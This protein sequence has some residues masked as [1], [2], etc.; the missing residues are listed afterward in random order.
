M[1]L[2]S[3]DISG[4]ATASSGPCDIAAINNGAPKGSQETVGVY[5]SYTYGMNTLVMLVLMAWN[6]LL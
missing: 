3:L 6:C 1:M 2:N 5:Y 4:N